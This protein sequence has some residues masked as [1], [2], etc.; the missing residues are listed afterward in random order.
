VA[1]LNV[2]EKPLPSLIKIIKCASFFLTGHYH[3]WL[4]VVCCFWVSGAI[5]GGHGW[6][7]VVAARFPLPVPIM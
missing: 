4:A 6:R 1:F 3:G 7:W 2:S 5:G